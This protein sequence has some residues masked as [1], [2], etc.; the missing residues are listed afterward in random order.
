[1][2]NLSART[3]TTIVRIICSF[4]LCFSLF[5]SLLILSNVKLEEIDIKKTGTAFGLATLS[6]SVY[7]VIHLFKHRKE[8]GKIS[9]FDIIF[10]SSF[11]IMS[12]LGLCSQF[13]PLMFRIGAI[14]YLSMPIVKRTESIARNRSK[15]NIS[16]NALIGI[17]DVLILLFAV[18]GLSEGLLGDIILIV[19]VGIFMLLYCLFNIALTALSNFNRELLKK[20]IRKTYAGEILFGLLL[21]IVAFSMAFTILEE[22]ISSFYD[23]LWY[24]FAIVTTTGFGD[25]TASTFLGRILSVILGIYGIIAVAIITSIIVNFYSEVKTIPEETLSDGDTK[26]LSD[27]QDDQS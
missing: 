17:F 14:L 22:N 24:C 11:F 10:A 8:H 12:V 13:L 6:L 3:K 23:A 26:P 20:I 21:L 19:L 16:L 25:Y 1:M 2:K 27:N 7:T 15:S 4:L 5:F 18:L 9:V